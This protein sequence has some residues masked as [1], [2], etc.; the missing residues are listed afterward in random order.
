M[1]DNITDPIIEAAEEVHDGV[2]V[3]Q[4]ESTYHRALEHEF[5]MNNINFSSEATIP[6]FY[7]DMIVG[8]RRLDM[9]VKTDDGN[10]IVELKA[11]NKS[12]EEQLSDYISILEEDDNFDIIGGILIRFNDELECILL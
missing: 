10:V 3:G 11:G 4:T 12:G 6:I 7:K 2:G 8:K 5:S 1:N 9:M